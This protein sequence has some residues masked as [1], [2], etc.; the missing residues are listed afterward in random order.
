M[1]ISSR[2]M[3]KLAEQIALVID[4]ALS[5]QANNPQEF[6][7]DLSL[8]HNFLEKQLPLCLDFEGHNI[9]VKH[10]VAKG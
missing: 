5:P 3:D 8:I 9:S 10:S 7:K 4:K 6:V 2:E 1:R